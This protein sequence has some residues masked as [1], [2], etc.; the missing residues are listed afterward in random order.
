MAEIFS[1]APWLFIGIVAIGI[2]WYAVTGGKSKN[3]GDGNGNNNNRS[4]SSSSQPSQPIDNQT[5][6]NQNRM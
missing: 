2:V 6:N 5:T 4:S 3:E 1:N